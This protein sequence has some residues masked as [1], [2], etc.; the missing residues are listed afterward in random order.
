MSATATLAA[1]HL[2]PLAKD[3]DQNKVTPG[4]LGFIVFAVIGG[5]VWLLM[6]SMNKHMQR[7]NFEE[8]AEAAEPAPQETGSAANSGKN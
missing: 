2:M 3:L 4:V 7:V 5:A 8:A 1:G 6:K